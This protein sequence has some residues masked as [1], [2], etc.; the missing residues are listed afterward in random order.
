MATGKADKGIPLRGNYI[1]TLADGTR[2]TITK[3][4]CRMWLKF[5]PTK[6]KI[7]PVAKRVKRKGKRA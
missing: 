6:L 3:I 1:V 4:G 7:T 5:N 2:G